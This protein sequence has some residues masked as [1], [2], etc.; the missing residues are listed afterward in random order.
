[1]MVI[2]FKKCI[3]RQ[4]Q[5]CAN[6]IKHTFTNLDGIYNL[7]LTQTIWHSLLLPGYKPVQDVTV[8]NT[9][10]L[11]QAQEKNNAIKR[12][13]K[14]KIYDKIAAIITQHTVL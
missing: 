11:N 10:R 4:F 7:I 6:I 14:H 5:H 3:I 2:H 1:M 13:H 12:H 8:Q 9:M